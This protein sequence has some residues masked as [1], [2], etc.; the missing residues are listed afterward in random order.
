MSDRLLDLRVH[1]AILANRQTRL[2][3]PMLEAR[4]KRIKTT[5]DQAV[6]SGDGDGDGGGGGEQEV[7]ADNP[8]AAAA[9]ATVDQG[10]GPVV[11]ESK[12][13]VAAAAGAQMEVDAV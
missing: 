10:V 1:I 9:A 11:P 6:A 2:D 8:A 12:E 7:A 13:M 3:N 5:L 4:I